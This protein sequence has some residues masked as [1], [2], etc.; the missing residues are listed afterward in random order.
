MLLS[1]LGADVVRVDR[2]AAAGRK[3]REST[4]GERS[5][6]ADLKVPEG[7]LIATLCVW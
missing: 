2:P 3:P 1:E 7:S 6:V 5:V 4:R